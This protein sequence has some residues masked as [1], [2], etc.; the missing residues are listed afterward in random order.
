MGRGFRNDRGEDRL[1]VLLSGVNYGV[2]IHLQ[3]VQERTSIFLAAKIK[4]VMPCWRS[5]PIRYEKYHL[6]VI[7]AGA[8]PRLVSLRG[9][10]QIF[11]RAFTSLTSWSSPPQPQ[12]TYSPDLSFQNVILSILLPRW[13]PSSRLRSTNH[14]LVLLKSELELIF[15]YK[16]ILRNCGTPNSTS[17]FRMGVNYFHISF[18]CFRKQD[19]HQN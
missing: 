14:C 9:F 4:A 3:D 2:W 7:K 6:V 16:E 5:R 15:A 12:A 10:I 18:R 13:R 8:T 11:R 17:A 1:V 19:P